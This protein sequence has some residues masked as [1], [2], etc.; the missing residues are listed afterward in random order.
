[1]N[2]PYARS[3]DSIEFNYEL[4]VKGT[5][6]LCGCCNVFQFWVLFAATISGGVCAT[7][8]WIIFALDVGVWDPACQAAVWFVICLIIASGSRY[9]KI[10]G[11]DSGLQI[12][13]GPCP[14]YQRCLCCGCCVP[15]AR[16][17]INYDSITSLQMIEQSQCLDGCGITENRCNNVWV[18]NLGCCVPSV[19]ITR[20]Y[21]P[22]AG[23]CAF[24]NVMIG[25]DS[26]DQAQELVSF[27]EDKI[28]PD[29]EKGTRKHG[30]FEGSQ[31]ALGLSHV[32][33]ATA[34]PSYANCQP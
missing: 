6:V 30:T 8:F 5:P 13:Y 21:D 10:R 23:C 20:R 12:F 17:E 32:P 4:T 27:L 26:V 14:C 24:T 25:V 29:V 28:N 22:R 11:D 33:H 31:P 7:M 18:M 2:S 16:G 3:N 34:P 19:I 9:F 1:M 15:R